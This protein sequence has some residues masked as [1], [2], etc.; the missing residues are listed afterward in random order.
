V[1]GKEEGRKEDLTQE[2]INC[3]P[4]ISLGLTMI[5]KNF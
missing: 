3:M 4:S 2:K 1:E 5:L